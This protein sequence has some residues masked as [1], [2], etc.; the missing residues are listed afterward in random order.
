M[1]VKVIQRN[2][3]LKNKTKIEE[4]IERNVYRKKDFQLLLTFELYRRYTELWVHALGS[5]AL[6]FEWRVRNSPD[7]S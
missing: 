2:H 1:T 4:K 6:M 5:S 3:V 7:Q